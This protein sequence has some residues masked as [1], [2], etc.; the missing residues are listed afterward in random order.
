MIVEGNAPLA[1][2]FAINIIAIYQNYKWNAYVEEHRNDPK[3]WHGLVDNDQWQSTYLTGGDRDEIRFWMG[4]QTA[5][6]SSPNT[7][8]FGIT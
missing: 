5:A 2:A 1:A 7:D 8:R 6:A 4:G 3:V